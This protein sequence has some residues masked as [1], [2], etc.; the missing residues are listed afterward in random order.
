[1]KN[2]LLHLTLCITFIAF[3]GYAYADSYP[4]DRSSTGCIK[5][6]CINGFGVYVYPDDDIYEGSWREG[7]QHG[8][9][10]FFIVDSE[11][12]VDAHK[13]TGQWVD[14]KQHGKFYYTYPSGTRKLQYWH[15]GKE[16]TSLVE[17]CRTATTLSGAYQGFVAIV[18]GL[19]AAANGGDVA[20]S[21]AWGYDAA[22][23]QALPRGVELTCDQLLAEFN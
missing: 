20:E 12:W 15:D 9:G 7:K 10:T 4:Y 22:G 17:K 5:G 18:N 8:Q 23:D 19:F 16:V 14:G 2:L 11:P 21:A 13:L 3:A 1:M 6:D